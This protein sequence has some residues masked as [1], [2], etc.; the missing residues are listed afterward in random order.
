M[1][2]Y[3]GHSVNIPDIYHAKDFD[4][5]GTMEFDKRTG[6]RSISS[7]TVPLKNHLGEVIGVITVV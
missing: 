1:L 4:F 5:T 7:L 2:R 6:Y 3:T